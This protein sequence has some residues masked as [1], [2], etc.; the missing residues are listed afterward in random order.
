M[1]FASGITDGGAQDATPTPG[2]V[3]FLPLATAAL[4]PSA[5]VPASVVLLRALYQPGASEAFLADPGSAVG[6][7][8]AGTPTIRLDGATTVTRAAMGGTPG[9]Q[10]PL[11]A[12]TE[13][14]LGPGDAVVFPAYT[15]GTISNTGPVPAV[16]LFVL[17]APADEAIASPAAGTP[18]P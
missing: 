7:V 1:V 10:E 14:S 12:G 9:P 6:Y 8:E 16:L 13:V 3:A 4:D 11:S 15:G 5:P 18:M 17:L 2:D